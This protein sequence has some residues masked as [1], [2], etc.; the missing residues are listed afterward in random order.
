M[1]RACRRVLREGGRLGFQVIHVAAGL[2]ARDYQLAVVSGP[3]HVGAEAGYPELLDSAGFEV[4]E[5]ADVTDEYRR[6]LAARME[7]SEPFLNELRSIYGTDVFNERWAA[8][9]KAIEAT[10]AGLLK[11]ASVFATRPEDEGAI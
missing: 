7:H 11:R 10:Q 3:D 6:I 2:S 9:A 5:V 8:R 1:L 4:E